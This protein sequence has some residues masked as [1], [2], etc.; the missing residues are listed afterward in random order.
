MRALRVAAV[1]KSSLWTGLVLL[2]GFGA[3][4][5]AGVH[6]GLVKLLHL[7]PGTAGWGAGWI[8]EP[9]LI[10]IVAGLI[11]I[12]AILRMSGGDV[13]G[14]AR[15]A[16]AVALGGS[17]ALNMFG[18]WTPDEGGWTASLAQAVAH[19][20][21][22][23]GAAGTAW[24]IGVVIDYTTRAKPWENAPRVADLHLP[25]TSGTPSGRPS[26]LSSGAASGDPIK[27]GKRPPVPVDRNNLPDDIRRLLDDVRAA[28][29][30]G[31]L[32]P[33]PSG[34]AIYKHVMRGKGDRARSGT[35][36]G[37]VAGWRP[38]LRAV[39]DASSATG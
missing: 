35:V 28:I 22:A 7:T 15:A 25:Q 16:E 31:T 1:Q 9:L 37:L 11:V 5:T 18:G 32:S 39:G 2:I 4:S 34:Y 21:G 8:L 30:D 12:R 20:V 36:A 3:W 17:L 33:D 14:R 13:D 26:V 29:T 38:P 23:I 24:L 10:T 6:E 27:R 19:S